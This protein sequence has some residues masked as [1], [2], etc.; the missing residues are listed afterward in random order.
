MT[1]LCVTRCDDVR[2]EPDLGR[3]ITKPF[4]PGD[5]L[6]AGQRTRLD[7]AVSRILA[8]PE[9]DVAGALAAVHT[10]FG[11]RHRDLGD[12]LERNAAGASQRTVIPAG[13][14]PARRHLIGAYFTH[15]YSIE[16]AALSNPSIVIGPDQDGLTPGQTRF[17]MSL[18]AIGE[19]HVSC[20]EFRSGVIDR[21]LRVELEPTSRFAATGTRSAADY[22][23]VHFRTKLDELGICN[24]IVGLVLDR[25]GQR[26]T[27]EQLER[28]MAEL[29]TAEF[30]RMM[31]TD[32]VHMLRWLA[33]SSYRVGFPGVADVSERV[34]FPAG[35]TESRGM[36]DVRLVRF[37]HDDGTVVYYGTY[38]AFDGHAILPQLIETTD[39]VS[40]TVSTLGGASAHNKGIALFPRKVHG[41][42][43]ALGRQDNVNNFLMASDDVHLW[44]SAQLIQEPKRPWELMQLGNCGSPL[45]TAAGWLVITHGV[46]PMRSYS[47]G[48][49]LLDLDDPAKVIGH[50]KEPLLAP[51]QD[52][53][54]GYVPNVVYSCGSMIHDDHL[55]LPYGF[56]DVG[57]RIAT[58][59]LADLLD[60]LTA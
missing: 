25:V 60:L 8:I 5:L 48:A 23:R 21:D 24:E 31:V 27:L 11:G 50:L 10:E 28:A 15:E 35:P 42:F 20:I 19:G 38:T 36:E 4:L 53:R 45:E 46:G 30:D 18:R 3:V 22:D 2:I 34:I 1:S 13:L 6:A 16:A 39:F 37:V 47:L 56:A 12:V 51:S 9:F 58:V 17:V 55:V 29:D 59:P 52:E 7:I 40:F 57:A 41:R 49:L 26:F 44:Q 14:S 43:L 33:S 32:T 54:E